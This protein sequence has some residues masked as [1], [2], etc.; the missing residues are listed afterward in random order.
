MSSWSSYFQVE[1]KSGRVSQFAPVLQSGTGLGP[2]VWY[3]VR[4]FDRQ[5]NCIVYNYITFALRGADPERLL[6]SVSYTGTG[7]PGTNQCVVGA[8]A[9]S[10]EFAY[11]GD[12]EDKRTTYRFGVASPMTARLAAISTKVGANYVRRDELSY[13]MRGATRRSLL[14]T[15]NLCAGGACGA[16][17]LPPITF[18]YQQESR[19]FDMWNVQFN[20]QAL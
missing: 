6:T 18:S 8:D 10:V 20:G 16:E 5:G 11:T 7:S 12:R 15:V 19:T 2:D 3:L 14:Q 1:H 13:A 17:K 9:R 4:E